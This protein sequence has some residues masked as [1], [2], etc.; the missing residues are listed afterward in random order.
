[1]PF[2]IGIEIKPQKCMM[3]NDYGRYLVLGTSHR[4]LSLLA[5][6]PSL[7]YRV[8]RLRRFLFTLIG[9]LQLESKHQGCDGHMTAWSL[10]SSFS[11]LSL[12]LPAGKNTYFKLSLEMKPDAQPLGTSLSHQKLHEV[13][14]IAVPPSRTL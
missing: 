10:P 11:A 5:P 8:R 2:F 6:S 12:T 13:L 4:R 7:F 3:G 9:M 14:A 1:M